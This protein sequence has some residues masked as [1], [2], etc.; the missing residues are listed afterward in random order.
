VTFQP[1]A[2]LSF[3]SLH[4]EAAVTFLRKTMQVWLAVVLFLIPGAAWADYTYVSIDF[5]GMPRTEANG[6]NDFGQVVGNYYDG[7]G[8]VHGFVL[9]G[10]VYSTLD[11]PHPGF[12]YTNLNGINDNGDIVGIFLTSFVPNGCGVTQSFIWSAGTFTLIPDVPGSMPGTTKAWAINN[13]GT[14]VGSYVDACFC[15]MH[16]FVYSGGV[17]TTIDRPGYAAS[18]AHGINDAGDVVGAAQRSWGGGSARGFLLSGGVY[19]DVDHPDALAYPN[20]STL[21]TGVNDSGAIVGALSTSS[22]ST[23]VYE[24]GAFTM[25]AV[26]NAVS[27]GNTQASINSNGQVAGTYFDAGNNIHGF[28]ASPAVS[29]T[30]TVGPPINPDGSSVFKANRG[31][32]PIKFALALNGAST[33]DLP[34]A[35]ISVFRLNGGTP[36]PVNE[37]EYSTPADDGTAFRISDCQYIYHLAARALGVGTYEVRISIGGTV[38]GT[39]TFALR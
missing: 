23:F 32:V 35:T 31:T 24:G 28:V 13:A 1:A 21:P 8:V 6:I 25:L 39:A 20:G 30:A 38:V 17:F 16:A 3:P 11:Y 4:E 37:S 36:M 5:P 29:Y 14:V 19:I 34:P 18:S 26:P 33:C 15:T 12:T 9:S 27:T 22:T 7:G 10:G 2:S